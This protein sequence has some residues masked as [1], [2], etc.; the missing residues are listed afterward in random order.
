MTSI[1]ILKKRTELSEGIL[2]EIE[3][4]MRERIEA[5]KNGE[6]D[7]ALLIEGIEEKEEFSDISFGNRK[8]RIATNKLNELIMKVRREEGGREEEDLS[9]EY[10]IN[11]TPWEKATYYTSHSGIFFIRYSEL[12]GKSGFPVRSNWKVWRKK[13]SLRDIARLKAAGLG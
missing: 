9:E 11:D 3:E 5:V 1:E 7:E 2:E 8:V 4:T 10:D 13:L 12:D 6:A